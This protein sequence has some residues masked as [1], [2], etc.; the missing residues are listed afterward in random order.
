M[1]YDFV[2]GCMVVAIVMAG[3]LSWLAWLLINRSI[4]KLQRRLEH[5]SSKVRQGTDET[6]IMVHVGDD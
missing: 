3:G 5:L 6:R 2:I 4:E 1:R